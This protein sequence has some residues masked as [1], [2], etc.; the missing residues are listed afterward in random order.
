LAL[1]SVISGDPFGRQEGAL[2]SL[3]GDAEE[4]AKK[5]DSVVHKLGDSCSADFKDRSPAGAQA[6]MRELQSAPFSVGSECPCQKRADPF[7][8]GNVRVRVD[9]LADMRPP[10]NASARYPSICNRWCW[11]QHRTKYLLWSLDGNFVAKT[12]DTIG[13][14]EHLYSEYHNGKILRCLDG[15]SS[16]LSKNLPWQSDLF[17]LNVSGL[18]HTSP[19]FLTERAYGEYMHSPY[20]LSSWTYLFKKRHRQRGLPTTPLTGK[21]IST[22]ARSVLHLE[23]FSE[24]NA[25]LFVDAQFIVTEAGITLFDTMVAQLPNVGNT[26]ASAPVKDEEVCL[27]NTYA[28]AYLLQMAMGLLLQDDSIFPPGVW[29]EA[30]WNEVSAWPPPGHRP[31]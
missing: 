11:T 9:S 19:V 31:H 5:N 15:G 7:G 13:G 14:L 6:A 30:L 8:G 4:V 3:E 20:D 25:L 18:D 1:V 24:A 29:K 23:G 17:T 26:C 2:R 16:V 10:A 12:E 28:R 27:G 22:L 21:N